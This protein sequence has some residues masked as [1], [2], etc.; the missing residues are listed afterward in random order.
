M[1]DKASRHL[2]GA[3]LRAGV[4]IYMY[5]RGVL[6]EK[7]FIYDG[8]VTV[9]GSSNIDPRSFRLNYE[10]SVFVV[11]ESFAAPVVARHNADL[12][13]AEPYTLDRWRARPLWQ[14]FTDWLWSL[15]RGQ[16]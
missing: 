8:M 4:A 15:A 1:I 6:H 7:T 9:V 2:W 12:E 5:T 14:R 11:G 3:L 10:L 13:E 16:L